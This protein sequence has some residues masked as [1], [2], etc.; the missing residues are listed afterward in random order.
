MQLCILLFADDA[1]LIA[2]SV[3]DLQILLNS[4]DEFCAENELRINTSK[5]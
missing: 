5:T 3:K 1:V 2:K 4:F